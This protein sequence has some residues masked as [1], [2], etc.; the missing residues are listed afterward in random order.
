MNAVCENNGSIPL[1]RPAGRRCHLR[2]KFVGRDIRDRRQAD[3]ADDEIRERLNDLFL[4][5]RPAD[6]YRRA[7]DRNS[8]LSDD[9][10][11]LVRATVSRDA[12]R[13]METWL[14]DLRNRAV[15]GDTDAVDL[16]LAYLLAG[17]H[18]FRSG[19][20]RDLI[21]GRLARAELTL[22]Q[23]ERARSIVYRCLDGRL[24]CRHPEIGQLAR[25]VADNRMRRRL[26]TQLHDPDAAAAWRAL[27]TL[28]RVRHPGLSPD[29]VGT[30]QRVVMRRAE[31]EP[32][33]RSPT[34]RLARRLRT[35]EWET[36]LLELSG[37]SDS[38]RVR[39]MATNLLEVFTTQRVK[40]P[41]P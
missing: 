1:L 23:R 36:E 41:G 35:S 34:A 18:Y 17:P 8:R 28:S 12:Q 3:R 26:R 13:S 16:A 2:S 32:W 5:T 33:L 21:V 15:G 19:Y 14:G 30:A 31:S 9:P 22:A 25:A 10:G 27:Q 6:E 37:G 11:W 38:K 20:S 7:A 39:R 24:H 29:D 40:R 4:A